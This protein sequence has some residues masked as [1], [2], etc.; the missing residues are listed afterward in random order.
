MVIGSL[1]V[2][3]GTLEESASHP[4]RNGYS[5]RLSRSLF[6]WVL[7]TVRDNV[8]SHPCTYSRGDEKGRLSARWSLIPAALGRGGLSIL[9][10]G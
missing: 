2:E 8:L 1:A 3:G 4:A 10:L 9:D 7:R 5:T 6:R